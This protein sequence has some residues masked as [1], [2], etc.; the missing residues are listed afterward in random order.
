MVRMKKKNQSLLID[1]TLGCPREQL[2]KSFTLAF[3]E[4]FVWTPDGLLPREA[5]NLKRSIFSFHLS[6]FQI[7][8]AKRLVPQVSA[9]NS[10]KNLALVKCLRRTSV[11]I[12]KWQLHGNTACQGSFWRRKV[13]QSVDIRLTFVYSFFILLF[14]EAYDKNK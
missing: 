6:S 1:Q 10:I 12:R 13:V 11:F 5:W 7:E 3:N 2:L 14:M 4:S 8:M 9:R